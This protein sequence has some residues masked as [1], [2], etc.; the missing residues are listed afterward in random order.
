MYVELFTC[1]HKL[2]TVN[3]FIVIVI[4]MFTLIKDKKKT[5]IGKNKG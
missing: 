1:V 4:C 5:F 2:N 3:T